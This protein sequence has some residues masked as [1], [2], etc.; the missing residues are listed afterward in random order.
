MTHAIQYIKGIVKTKTYAMP[1]VFSI[2][3]LILIAV[4][5][6]VELNFRE[7]E[8]GLQFDNAKSHTVIRWGTYIIMS[9]LIAIFFGKGSSFI[10]F[11][12]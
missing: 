9:F 11:Q 5:L 6:F 10:Y 7:K 8:F 4:L 3:I 1:E 2:P 12:F